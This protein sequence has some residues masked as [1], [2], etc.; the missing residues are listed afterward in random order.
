[1]YAQNAWQDDNYSPTR[2]GASMF[3]FDYSSSSPTL[4][5][6]MSTNALY[7]TVYN[8]CECLCRCL[9]QQSRRMR[10]AL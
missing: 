6:N 2:T 7:C 5:S 1:M 4:F 8:G 3:K 10:A 9:Q